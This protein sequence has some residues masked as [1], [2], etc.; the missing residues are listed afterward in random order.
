MNLKRT[1]IVVWNSLWLL[2]GLGSVYL[3]FKE[4]LSPKADLALVI[5]VFVAFMLSLGAIQQS[6]VRLRRSPSQEYN[7]LP[8]HEALLSALVRDYLSAPD[9]SPEFTVISYPSDE[10]YGEFKADFSWADR[11]EFSYNKPLRPK[12]FEK[13]AEEG[14]LDRRSKINY[15]INAHGIEAVRG[16]FRIP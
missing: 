4:I 10:Q 13:L 11:R 2:V 5:G 7:L 1:G 15:E 14:L 3:F 6:W 12:H 16:K 9:N 8:E